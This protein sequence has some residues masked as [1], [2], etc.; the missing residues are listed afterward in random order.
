MAYSPTP[1]ATALHNLAA[2]T[3]NSKYRLNQP[4]ASPPP[5]QNMNKRD[6]KR[7][8]MADRLAEISNNFARDRDEH[9]RDRIRGFSTDISFINNAALYDNQVLDDFDFELGEEQN[10]GATVGAQTGRTQNANP[11]SQGAPKLGKHAAMFVQDVNDALEEKD[12]ALTRLAV[13]HL[14][15]I[16]TLTSR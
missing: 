5:P 4:S 8:A 12:A 3:Y 15:Q 11:A 13:C 16:P 1:H 9:Y 14:P 2:G 6:K 10:A 7:Q